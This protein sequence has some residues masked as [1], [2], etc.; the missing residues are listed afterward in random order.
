MSH[1]HFFQKSLTLDM[2]NFAD[3][4]LKLS[5][6]FKNVIIIGALRYNGK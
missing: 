5:V 2:G 6:E 1:S 3:V 4:A